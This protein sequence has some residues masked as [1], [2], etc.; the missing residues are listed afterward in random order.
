[1][2]KHGSKLRDAFSHDVIRAISLVGFF[3]GLAE[4]EVRKDVE[5][6]RGVDAL[7][8]PLAFNIQPSAIGETVGA[9]RYILVSA[10]PMPIRMGR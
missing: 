4:A 6:S 3:V 2:W 1:M 9:K 5:L 7:R 10:L 8:S